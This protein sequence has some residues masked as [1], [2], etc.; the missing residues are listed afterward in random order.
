[1][2]ISILRFVAYENLKKLTLWVLAFSLNSNKKANTFSVNFFCPGLVFAI[3]SSKSKIIKYLNSFLSLKHWQKSTY[4]LNNKN[5]K[6]N[7][8]TI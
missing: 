6:K 5:N 2:D 7:T 8:T 4:G 3:F 1:L